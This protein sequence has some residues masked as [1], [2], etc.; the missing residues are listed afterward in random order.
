LAIFG[1]IMTSSQKQLTI[2]WR[3]WIS[4]PDLG[5]SAVK[6]KIDTGARSSVLHAFDI[7]AFN[8][9]GKRM[10]RFRVHPN[11]RDNTT[12]VTAEAELIDERYVR[13][14]GGQS[15]L[16]P[17]ILT[18]VELLG[19]RWPIELTLTN[20]E[21]MVFRMLLGRQA[22]RRRFLVNANK[23]FLLSPTGINKFKQ[24]QEKQE[25]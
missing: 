11:Q 25:L 18:Q 12:T 4:L 7:E 19:Q 1:K 22:V 2:G 15:E 8:R 14:S 23:S 24:K 3:E 17:V 5:I 13:N 16:R 10:V 20:R 6:A 9:D 21:T